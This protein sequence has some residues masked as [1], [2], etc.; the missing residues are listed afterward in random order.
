MI[1]NQ[2]PTALF[3]LAIATSAA[4]CG[5][6]AT[7]GDEA[8]AFLSIQGD[9]NIYLEPEFQRPLTV[10]YHDA[11]GN[12]LAGEIRFEIEGEPSGSTIDINLS[13]T[14]DEGKS[15]LTLVAGENEATF[16]IKAFAELA[17]PTE[18]VINVKN[19]PVNPDMDIRGTY[20]VTSDFDIA[21]GVPGAVGV[22]I[23]NFIDMTD[24][25]NDPATYLLD[26]V[27]GESNSGIANAI[28][29]IRPF[30]DG[31]LNQLIIDAAPDIVNDIKQIGEDFGHV[32]RQFGVVSTLNISGDSIET[33]QDAV[34]TVI[35]YDFELSGQDYYFTMQELDA[36]TV[37]VDNVAIDY[38]RTTA[39]LEIGEHVVPVEYGAFLTLALN[40]VIIP[41][42]DPSA[43]NLEELLTS[44]VNCVDVG[45][46]IKDAI[47]NPEVP[48]EEGPLYAA[49]CTTA[50]QAAAN[51]AMDQL[52]ALDDNA[53][54][55]LQISGDTTMKDP[56]G[57]G[58]ADEMSKGDWAGS[59]E[60]VG[61]FGPL[62]ED[63]NPFTGDRIE[64]EN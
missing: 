37:V 13:A 9:P 2:F 39:L 47:E 59:M 33:S 14:N 7:T 60:Y 34:H 56:S 8:S 51:I 15:T 12:P 19:A 57:D 35:A 5:S 10:R 41:S 49:L 16:R 38:N 26:K 64:V 44:A 31:A 18:W 25:E 46:A 36:D 28:T 3:A 6:D 24:G 48:G 21:S 55:T 43:T 50:L 62:T 32:A 1:N 4:A 52:R 23:N 53:Q 29:G 61:A 58:I 54:V 63:A 45:I 11:D 17:D 40:D 22:V 20:R 30:L 42:I 27:I